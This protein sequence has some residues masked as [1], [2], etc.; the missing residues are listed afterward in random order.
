MSLSERASKPIYIILG[1]ALSILVIV[2]LL[3]TI[4]QSFTDLIGGVNS[5][6]NFAEFSSL[7]GILPLVFIVMLVIMLLVMI[8]R[9]D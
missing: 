5:S 9:S 6:S 2:A 7:V 4:D 3:P 1:L 8:F